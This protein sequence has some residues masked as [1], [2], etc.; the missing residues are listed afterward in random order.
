MK[1][2]ILELLGYGIPAVQVAAAVGCDDS[3]VSQLMADDNFRSQV[4]VKRAEK[5]GEAVALDRMLDSAEQTALE[6]MT[7]LIP[8]MTRPGEAARVYSILNAAKRRTGAHAATQAAPAAVVQLVLPEAKS[9]S[10]TLSHEKQVIE[11]E[12]RS[13]AT[14]P[15]RSVAAQLEARNARRLLEARAPTTLLNASQ[16]VIDPEK[17][18]TGSKATYTLV[19]QL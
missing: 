2:R 15:A 5:F 9:I 13:M 6:R 12:G 8:F 18:H 14:M 1:E 4:E 3:Y 11:I 10:F 16:Q 19:E 7:A 17:L